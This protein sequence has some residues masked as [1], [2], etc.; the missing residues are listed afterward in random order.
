MPTAL[1][2]NNSK[3]ETCNRIFPIFP[4]TVMCLP[5][6]KYHIKTTFLLCQ[7]ST[8]IRK[9]AKQTHQQKRQKT[10]QKGARKSPKNGSKN[11]APKQTLTKQ[12]SAENG[13][14]NG[15]RRVSHERV[16]G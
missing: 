3:K 13:T 5:Y 11:H 14:Q 6:S 15:P 7:I 4:K 10:S 8:S 1:E 12:K 16:F 2:E 9:N